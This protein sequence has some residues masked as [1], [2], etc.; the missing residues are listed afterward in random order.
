MLKAIAREGLNAADGLCLATEKLAG[1]RTGMLITVLFHSLYPDRTHLGDPA[2]APNQDITVPVFR[3]FVAA[4]LDAGYTVVTPA[5]VDAGLDE[6]GRHLMITFD[7]G[8]FNNTLALAVL[9]EFRVPA[10]FFISTGHV[11]AGKAFWWDAFSRSLASIGITGAAQRR[12]IERVKQRPTE[13]IEAE[14]LR[15]FGERVL[16]PRGDL[17]RPFTPGELRQFAASPWVHLGNHTRNHAILTRCAP[18]DIGP[19]IADCQRDLAEWTGRRPIA[20]AYPNGNH[21]PAVVRAA[22]EAGLRLGFTVVPKP[23]LLPLAAAAERMSIGR[24]LLH[25]QR[26]V[27]RQC[28]MFGARAVPSHWV[29]RLLHSAY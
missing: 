27:R 6:A 14:L 13:A 8:Y 28:R 1:E 16:Q 11:R 17:D 25:G 9:Q 10:T 19:H 15:R 12:E 23:A 26:D 7:D 5:E 20:I 24:F 22:G 4:M 29:Q 2:L 21:S 18:Q 3:S